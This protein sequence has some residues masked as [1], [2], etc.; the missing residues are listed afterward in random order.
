MPIWSCSI[1]Q[2]QILLITIFPIVAV[3]IDNDYNLS[4]DEDLQTTVA[5]K[6][7]CLK[8]FKFLIPIF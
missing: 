5:S 7:L 3:V 6:G 2:L 8:S 1:A 4:L